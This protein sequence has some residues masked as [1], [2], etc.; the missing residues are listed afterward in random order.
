MLREQGYN[1]QVFIDGQKVLN[2]LQFRVAASR[3][4]SQGTVTIIPPSVLVDSTAR[5][6]LAGGLV[7]IFLWVDEVNDYV[8][9]CEGFIRGFTLKRLK[10]QVVLDIHFDL[11]T[12]IL[13][14]YYILYHN[15]MDVLLKKEEVN[16]APD[17]GIVVYALKTKLKRR[18]SEGQNPMQIIKSLLPK[19]KSKLS[20]IIR[21]YSQRDVTPEQATG[22]LATEIPSQ[23]DHYSKHSHDYYSWLLHKYAFLDRTVDLLKGITKVPQ[24]LGDDLFMDYFL[25]RVQVTRGFISAFA[26]FQSLLEELRAEVWGVLFPAK[27][28]V[29]GKAFPMSFILTPQYVFGIP[30]SENVLSYDDV[31][32]IVITENFDRMPT[33]YLAVS[34]L[35]LINEMTD[36]GKLDHYSLVSREVRNI[37]QSRMNTMET[38]FMG[39]SVWGGPVPMI[40]LNDPL[41]DFYLVTERERQYVLQALMKH[42]IIRTHLGTVSNTFVTFPH[43]VV[44]GIAGG[45]SGKPNI[46][47]IPGI[48][49]ILGLENEISMAIEPAVAYALPSD[50]SKLDPTPL[51][52]GGSP[53]ARLKKLGKKFQ[54]VG[55]IPSSVLDSKDPIN[56]AID[57]AVPPNWSNRILLS[58]FGILD[59]NSLVPQGDFKHYGTDI[60]FKLRA[61]FVEYMNQKFLEEG[62]RI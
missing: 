45:I 18:L 41:G 37:A 47:F 35:K 36:W 34:R 6:I 56:S 16:A 57:H 55:T 26:I 19:G 54:L 5:E 25:G 27:M 50:A 9:V 33:H 44:P 22:L 52:K 20:Q 29:R 40:R 7:Q 49:S 62:E 15:L 4:G 53:V 23:W 12:T 11:S 14:R 59:G 43:L 58:E 30:I 38:S 28:M 51:I 3:L 32:D 1:F 61:M 24:L 8:L 39:Y 10:G 2:A 48:V 21:Q 60:Y 17:L 42:E 46:Y 13:D 31:G